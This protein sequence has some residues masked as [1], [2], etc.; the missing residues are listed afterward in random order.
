MLNVKKVAAVLKKAKSLYVQP[1]DGD[2]LGWVS[3][4]Y[5]AFALTPELVRAVAGINYEL[6]KGGSVVGGV[7]SDRCPDLRK[8]VDSVGLP[9]N[10]KPL[11]FYYEGENGWL[12]KIFQRESGYLL[13]DKKYW[14]CFDL[15]AEIRASNANLLAYDPV[16]G[17][18]AVVT[19]MN[20]KK[21]NYQITE[22][23]F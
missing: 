20:H 16:Q 5:A 6:L 11:P 10:A 22:E 9:D 14:D 13:I 19:G 1:A 23:V 3:D 2:L 15:G 17:V 4:S 7:W 12:A 18:L 21:F 8:L